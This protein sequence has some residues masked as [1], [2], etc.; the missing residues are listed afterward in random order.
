MKTIKIFS[1]IGEIDSF[2]I[3]MPIIKFGMIDE[4]LFEF[5]ISKSKLRNHYDIN[6][7]RIQKNFKDL[8][9]K[10]QFIIYL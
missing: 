9:F 5:Y 3:N 7:M 2:D 10:K 1:K 4:D 8:L 6:T